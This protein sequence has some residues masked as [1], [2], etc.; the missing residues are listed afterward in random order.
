[1]I[2]LKIA[3]FEKKA[4]NLLL[5]SIQFHLLRKVYITLPFLA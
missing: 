3:L 1:M 2:T 5:T 4:Y